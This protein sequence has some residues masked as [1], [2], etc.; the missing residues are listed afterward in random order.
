MCEKSLIKIFFLSVFFLLLS[1][2]YV[3][4]V[5]IFQ[6]SYTLHQF[7]IKALQKHYPFIIISH[8][9]N[10]LFDGHLSVK[11]LYLFVNV[12][13]V[14]RNIFVNKVISVFSKYT[15]FRKMQLLFE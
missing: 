12:I 7:Y 5:N 15:Y 6:N 14:H 8:F 13:F 2:Y 3:L 11:Y 4:N 1:I 10:I 9:P